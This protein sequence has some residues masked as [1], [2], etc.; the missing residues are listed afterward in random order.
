[1]PRTGGP[2]GP[3]GTPR[4]TPGRSALGGGIAF[5]SQTAS[6][7]LIAYLE[8]NQGDAT[9]LVAT[10]N[11]NSAAPIILATGKPVLPLGGFLGSEP[12]LTADDLAAKVRAGQVR[13]FL[14]GGD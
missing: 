6:A 13:F 8:A 2:A 7:A 5:G 14:L 4:L 1:A 11:A 9:Y 12:I 10:T 3:C